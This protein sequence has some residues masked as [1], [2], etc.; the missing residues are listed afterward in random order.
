[1]MHVAV[2][3]RVSTRSRGLAV[4]TRELVRGLA[5]VA[6][7]ER[8][9]LTVITGPT[10]SAPD[11][12]EALHTDVHVDALGTA[13]AF[14]HLELPSL[15]RERGVDLLHAPHGVIP[16]GRV[17]FARMITVHNLATLRHPDDVGPA[18]RVLANVRL[19]TAARVADGVVAVSRF[20]ADELRLLLG[21][22]GN[23]LVIPSG[24][25]GMAADHSV[26]RKRARRL[27]NELG[28][29]PGGYLVAVGGFSA[30]K[31]LGV[32]LDALQHAGLDEV[33][34][35]L[36]GDDAGRAA[37]R[38]RLEA[39]SPDVLVEAGALP[40]ESL[41]DLVASSAGVLHPSRYQGF[42]YVPLEA[43]ALGVPVVSSSLP[44]VQEACGRRVRFIPADDV[45]AWAEA[46]RELAEGAITSRRWVGR[47]F[48][49]VAR[50]TA[51]AYRQVLA[52]R[53]VRG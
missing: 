7:T 21:D 42:A 3:A 39:L 15:L 14:E 26:D 13:Q 37:L 45:T 28:L 44:S 51:E 12:V 34:L 10:D 16:L 38:P 52:R 30:R 29:V 8:W 46:M 18:A 43:L 50:D 2:D 40:D 5:S 19:Q 31:N 6:R 49:D 47:T 11:G 27:L 4:Y 48:D 1:M 36:V 22:V 33:P 53:G 32:L 35:V 23:L 20:L 25:P 17:P 9:R 41:L 24:T